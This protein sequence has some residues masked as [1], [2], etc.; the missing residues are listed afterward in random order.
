MGKTKKEIENLFSVSKNISDKNYSSDQIKDLPKPVKRYFQYALQENQPYISYAR[1]KHGGQ[2]RTSEK[3]LPIKG[4]EYFTSE[5]PGIIWYAKIPFVSAKDMYFKGKGNLVIKLL[6]FIKVVD[7]KGKEIDQGELLRWLSETTIFPTALLP[8]KNLKWE[9]IDENSAKVI[10]SDYNQTVDGTFF[11]NDLGQISHFKAK[12]YKDT[13][14]EDWTCSYKD[15]REVAE[16][17]IP[18]YFEVKWNLVSGDFCYAK[19]NIEII[20]Y[21]TPLKY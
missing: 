7:A 8:S 13:T 10:F 20:D 15:Y 1:L 6:S 18:F 19:F 12:R 5:K 2:F 14:L 3:W 17:M 11:F 9:P 21:N 16:M 4:K